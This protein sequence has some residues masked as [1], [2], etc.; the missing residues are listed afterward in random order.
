[1]QVRE[2]DGS[3]ARSAAA[4]GRI[5][6]V[7]AGVA[8]LAAAWRLRRLLPEVELVVLERQQRVGGLI[9][10]EH[11]PGGFLL[12]HGA[13]CL[14]T[15]KPWGVAAVRE[16]GLGD[17]IVVGSEPR[18][19][20]VAANG[21]LH[22]LPPL[23]A[24]ATPSSAI[25]LA[26]S[27]LLGLRAKAR[28]VIEPCVPCRRTA[29]D[30]SVADFVARRFGSGVLPALVDP[31]L[32]GVYGGATQELSAEACLPRLRAMERSAG[33]IVRGIRRARR[34]RTRNPSPLP[35]M[36]SLRD[37]MGSLP[38]AFASAVGDR[39]RLG[40][41]VER[42][43][44]RGAGWRLDTSAGSFD[45]DGIVL[46][47]PAWAAAD[48]LE[49]LDRELA[50]E[51]AAIRHVA[52]DCV[53]LV[54]RRADV[55]H[56]LDGTGFVMAAGESRPTQAC[57]W[58][59]RKWPGRAPEGWVVLRSVLRAAQATDADLVA[60][61]CTDLRDLLGVTRPPEIVRVRR[62]ARA[63]PIYEVGH[64]GRAAWILARAAA[65][66]TVALAGNA[67]GGIGIPDCVRSG[68]AAADR[69]VERLGTAPARIDGVRRMAESAPP[70][71]S[72]LL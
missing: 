1:M 26:Q 60:L 4:V 47:T 38:A 2:D 49:P 63:T 68:E 30:E 71:G 29:A 7:G 32:R 52:L 45:V 48:L 10:T 61:A 43:S 37:G 42:L 20:F 72:P 31:L 56:P 17:A 19:A 62:L 39:L 9:D 55:P 27:R 46:A 34:A 69:L 50:G 6:V 57:T 28:L 66:G 8:G 59:S 21:R 40:V 14:L 12:E 53:S 41:A 3:G 24:G 36:V 13:D 15:T 54:W 18:R 58:A 64:L 44:R 22:P 65:L 23:F 5:A 25:A 33:G 51:L 11:L 67:Y 35:E 70:C 16:L